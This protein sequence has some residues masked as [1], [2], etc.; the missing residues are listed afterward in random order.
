M[1]N[2]FRPTSKKM[3]RLSLALRAAIGVLSMG[4]YFT[5][6]EDLGFWLLISGAVIEFIIQL[7]SGDDNDRYSDNYPS[8]DHDGRGRY[9]SYVS[10]VLVFVL[11]A[12]MFTSCAAKRKLIRETTTETVD[13]SWTEKI[14]VDVPVK[15]GATPA[16][17]IESL[18]EVFKALLTPVINGKAGTLPPDIANYYYSV[19]DT[20]GRLEMRFWMNAAGQLMT[21]CQLRDS[22]Y[23]VEVDQ[24]NRLIK[25]LKTDKEHKTIVRYKVPLWCW[26]I[27]AV[28][29]VV[30]VLSIIGAVMRAKS[31]PYT[32]ARN[33]GKEIKDRL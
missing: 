28:F 9:P 29:L 6:H 12:I 27:L 8:G 5:Q 17:N 19:P 16:V 7:L 14:S 11:V 25:Q 23:Q 22:V 13:S 24:K 1:F 21:A 33:I 18:K 30:I 20:T 15:G 10:R 2:Y 26:I 3:L 4:S 31:A 32:I